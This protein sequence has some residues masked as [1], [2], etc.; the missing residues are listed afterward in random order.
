M[1]FS[2]DERG[3]IR[4]TGDYRVKLKLLCQRCLEAMEI[5]LSNPFNIGLVADGNEVPLSDEFEQVAM[6]G[7]EIALAPLIEDEVLLGLPMSPMHAREDCPAKEI[8][9]GEREKSS[10]FAVL[11]NLKHDEM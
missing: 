1:V 9:D 2:K 8:R 10:P 6:E 7:R 4:I 11:K 5:T 3:V